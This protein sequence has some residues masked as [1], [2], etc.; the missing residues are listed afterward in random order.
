MKRKKIEPDE[1]FSYGPM[2]V[3][4]FGRFV[5]MRTNWSEEGYA[6]FIKKLR[7]RA[8]L[9]EQE[10]TVQIERV[11]A[12]IHRN[13]PLEL[14][15]RAYWQMGSLHMELTSETL[16][17][18]NSVVSLHLLEFIHNIVASSE[19][20]PVVPEKVSEDDWIAISE[21]FTEL[22]DKINRQFLMCEGALIREE[23]ENEEFA[24][25]RYQALGHWINVRGERHSVHEKQHLEDLLLCHSSQIEAALGISAELLIEEIAKVHASLTRGIMLALEEMHQIYDQAT[26]E[27]KNRNQNTE[28]GSLSEEVLSKQIHTI[29]SELGLE[30]RA[31]KL[32]E[33]IF[34]PGLFDL[35]QIT[36]LPPSLL[37]L[38]SWREG[39]ETEFFSAGKFPGWPVRTP[40][41]TKR[42]F[43]QIGGR[44]YCFCLYGL[45]D[46]FYRVIHRVV[47]AQKSALRQEWREV[48]KDNSESLP[49]RYFDH[50]LPRNTQ[51]RDVYY[52]WFPNKKHPKKEWCETDGLVVFGDHL[53]VIEVKAGAFSQSSPM[54][55]FDAFVSSIKGLVEA[56]ARQGRRFVD[57]LHSFPEVS[58]F[59]SSRKEIGKLSAAQFRKI[60][61]CVVTIDPFTEIAAK[62]EHLDS[63]LGVE[64]GPIPTWAVSLDDL[65][66]ISEIFTS[67]LVFLHFLEQRMKAAKSKELR[68]DDE[69]DHVGL[70][71]AVNDY[72]MHASE[73]KQSLATHLT[74]SGYRKPIDEFFH[75]RLFNPDFPSPFA[76]AI[77]D[78]IQKIL[79]FC[80][81]QGAE[82]MVELS[83][84]L[85]DCS[86]EGREGIADGIVS[87]LRSQS[88][89]K[90]IQ[91]PAMSG[92]VRL[93]IGC[94]QPHVFAPDRKFLARHAKAELLAHNE[95]DRKILE[96]F[97]NQKNEITRIEWSGI[98][99][100]DIPEQELPIY[101]AEAE[102]LR[103]RRIRQTTEQSGKIG[104]NTKC[105]CSSG[106]KFKHC[107]LER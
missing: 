27:W 105:P 59:D 81:E 99:L 18:H 107:C 49:L 42:P 11:A 8:P 45:F 21:G 66:G 51:Y 79:N 29:I 47:L 34:G 97:F 100:E 98:A 32:R 91:I 22:Y 58:L 10:I 62:I 87:A 26:A 90:R 85:L 83:S 77:P 88:S 2:E 43:L 103:M 89:R 7:E 80:V 44:F 64:I 12:I 93:T 94:W 70:Y 33:E 37:E 60:T 76:Q 86:Y 36:D 5:R 75:E 82:T 17:D 57:Y 48:Q 15:M 52:K 71:F 67:P 56:P 96:V 19:R 72:S 39:Q 55:N 6:D 102:K 65:R 46:N 74:F 30:Q 106:K 3:S 25:F 28:Q 84:F 68:L 35:Q 104:R 61:V 54:E 4:R 63:A 78:E 53:F 14:L 101:E 50:I 69:F 13:D 95:K 23:E 73:L 40:P 16:A 92:E 38:L 24:R 41:L 31:L 1:H 9:I 20:V